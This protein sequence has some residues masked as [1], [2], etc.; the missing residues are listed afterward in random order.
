MHRGVQFH[1]LIA[2]IVTVSFVLTQAITGTAAAAAMT[3]FGSQR[4]AH[5]HATYAITTKSAYYRS[6]WQA[7]INKWND[8]GAFHF[9]LS[10][11]KTAQ[12]HLT[13]DTVKEEHQM[14]DDV[15]VT[16]YWS[17]RSVLVAVTCY[18]NP[19]LMSEFHY[20]KSDATHVAEHELGHAMGLN[21]NPSKAS[22]MYFRNRSE[23]IHA[24]DIEGVKE[25]YSTPVGEA[26]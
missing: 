16:D 22:V 8:T 14:G 7:A 1:S 15:G 2:L 10:S 17:R 20:S 21:H 12:I 26:S 23:G 4:F 19:Q 25:R 9:K 24:V 18:L 3:P 11:N 13:T 6:V 5:A